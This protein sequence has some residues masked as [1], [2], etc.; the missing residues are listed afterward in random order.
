MASATLSQPQPDDAFDVGKL[1]EYQIPII[2][3]GYQ[4]LIGWTELFGSRPV[5]A[6]EGTTMSSPK[7]GA[8]HAKRIRMLKVAKDS[9]IDCRTKAINQIRALLV[10]APPAQ[11]HSGQAN[12]ICLHRANVYEQAR[13]QHPRRWTR[14]TRCWRQQEVV[15]INPPPLE[16]DADAAALAMDA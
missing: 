3:Q 7:S 14:S 13:Q 4:A 6:M 11:R 8:E 10:T 5:F 12:K 9:A 16:N 1:D 15:W 2:Q